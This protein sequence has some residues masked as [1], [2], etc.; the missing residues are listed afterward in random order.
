MIEGILLILFAIGL[1]TLTLPEM[2]DL[3]RL[4]HYRVKVWIYGFRN[5]EEWLDAR[6]E[7]L[8]ERFFES[9]RRLLQAGYSMGTRKSVTAFFLL[10][11]M[12][13]ILTLVLVAR[14][15]SLPL[16][17]LACLFSSGLPYLL[18]LC[19]VQGQRVANSQE[20]EVLVTELLNNYKIYYCNM[21]QA[22]EVTAM[23]MEGAPHCR[24]LLLNLARGLHKAA[25][26]G[27]VELLMEE[28]RFAIG[29]SWANILAANMYLACSGGL[30]VTE[31]LSD[32]A[33]SMAQARRLEEYGRRE[34]NEARWMLCYLVP[35]GGVL[36]L[37]GGCRFFGL[38]MAEFC[39]YQFQ[40]GPG[41]T[42]FVIWLTIYVAAVGVHL[43][44]TRRKFD[45]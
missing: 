25:T 7:R 20:G 21:R 36:M 16:T 45:V 15:I 44:L 42:W 17:L 1:L 5:E 9:V 3:Y 8:D 38:T 4:L 26:S 18:L 29:T 11:G 41:I 33:R 40:T 28:L 30:R 34:N 2:E 37:V 24:K 13:G 19:K 39:H 23:T 32:L 6:R 10:S 14:W 35:I 31:S 27:D 12:L 43:L 22:I